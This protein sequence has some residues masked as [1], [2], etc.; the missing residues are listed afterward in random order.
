[1]PAA[2]VQGGNFVAVFIFRGQI[3]LE[4][5]GL[6]GAASGTDVINQNLSW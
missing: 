1:M 6:L 2:A 3:R 4:V 5:L